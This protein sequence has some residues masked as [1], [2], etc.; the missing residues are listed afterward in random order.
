MGA[1]GADVLG[2]STLWLAS[3]TGRRRSVVGLLVLLLVVMTVAGAEKPPARVAIPALPRFGV[4]QDVDQSDVADPYILPVS[5]AV[6][7]DATPTGVVLESMTA[8]KYLRFGTTDWRSNVP[9]AVSSN[10]TDWTAI[11]DA[12]PI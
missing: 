9:T 5:A 6:A 11:A 1:A 12:L 3:P 7:G 10:L 4:S 2:D 8:T